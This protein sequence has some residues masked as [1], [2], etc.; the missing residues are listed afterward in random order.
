[1][2]RGAFQTRGAL[3]AFNTGQ[4]RSLGRPNSIHH[5]C[6]HNESSRAVAGVVGFVRPTQE[7]EGRISL[8][9]VAIV[10]LRSP[11]GGSVTELSSPGHTFGTRGESPQ[12]ANASQ[13]KAPV[14]PRE[15]D[16][17]SRQEEKCPDNCS[18]V[19]SFRWARRRSIWRPALSCFAAAG[20]AA[21]AWARAALERYSSCPDCV[22]QPAAQ[23]RHR[24]SHRPV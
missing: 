24:C 7:V 3:N 20:P 15:A 13:K 1:M 6:I 5:G 17:L 2:P 4:L 9:V 8:V 14:A 23:T 11:G 16:G 12:C 10:V 18:W 22:P 21:A 19:E